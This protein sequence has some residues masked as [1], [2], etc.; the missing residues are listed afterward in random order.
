MTSHITVLTHS[1]GRLA[2]LWKAD[3]T[4]AAYD[5]TKY[6]KHRTV[7][8]TSIRDLA[9]ELRE[10]EGDPNSAV[11]RGLYR[12]DEIAAQADAEFKRGR[13]RKIKAVFD[14]VPLSW[15][16]VEID[17][18]E[19]KMAD[20]VRDPVA[21]IDEFVTTQ[22]PQAFH[23][24]SYHWQ[25]SG[26]AGHVKNVGKL[27]A[28]VW[29]WLTA[30][31]ISAQVK[32]WAEG[33]ALPIDCSV[34]N[35]VQFHYTAAPV[36]EEGVTVP[37]PARSGFVEGL[38]GDEVELSIAV[39]PRDG[40]IAS[41]DS[42][43]MTIEPRLGWTLEYGR[44]VLMDC[45]Q[46]S[47]R[48]NWRSALSAM[49]HEF[50]GSEEAL[51]ICDLWSSQSAKYEGRGDVEK[52]WYSFGKYTG[53]PLTGKWLLKWRGECIARRRYNAKAEW[54]AKIAGTLDEFTLREKVCADIAKDTCVG[55]LEREALA[56]ALCDQLKT[57]GAHYPIAQCRKMVA[58][59]RKVRPADEEAVVPECGHG[60]V[61]VTDRDKFFRVD[62]DEWLTTQAFNARFNHTMPTDEHGNITTTASWACLNS[63]DLTVTRAMY[64]PWAEDRFEFEGVQ[65]VNL[66]RPS[67]V[68][69]ASGSI[70]TKGRTA[71]D[72]VLRHLRL[73]T[74]DRQVLVDTMVAWIA[75]NVQYPG[76][77]IRWAI[78]IKGIEGDGKSLLGS[79]MASVMGRTNVRDISPKVLGTDFN[80]Y[81]EGACVG[82]LEELKMTGHNRYDTLN[83]L[84]PL[85]TNDSIP[86]HR[87]GQ[88]EYNI[89]NTTNYLAFT[90]HSDALPLGDTDRRFMIVFTPF[91]SSD[92]LCAA[93]G[94]PVGGAGVYFDSLHAAIQSH[95]AELRQ[96]LLDYP[97]P[98]NFRP[99]SSAPMT[100]EKAVM[101]ALSRS[102]E[103]EA[104]REIIEKGALGVTT[105]VFSSKCLT[106]ALLHHEDGVSIATTAVNRVA[107]RLGYTRMPKK[108]WWNGSTHILWVRGRIPS[109]LDELK[110]LLDASLQF[111]ASLLD[112]F[113][114][115]G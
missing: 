86:I 59:K 80:G 91:A 31:Y 33:A 35:T 40:G 16:L 113:E 2:K 18:F 42:W 57:I 17:E 43:L 44:S 48:D 87:K 109:G 4:V 64:L 98:E 106:D 110:V 24:I 68:P 76:V 28:H 1:T 84:K 10:L 77:K 30:P 107:S 102:P 82:V 46:D 111:S 69:K 73:L 5:E 22:L 78:L 58:E 71:I 50:A 70:S 62:S 74:G 108:V 88:D 55:E 34:L 6:Y 41:D 12:G 11:I 45:D 72:L 8:V 92:D 54:T 53:Q 97:I 36:A 104:A 99:N 47:G 14:D 81:A 29:F 39:T 19:P 21:A 95:P 100:D 96:W 85:I 3:G 101:V 67:S 65:C 63:S 90:N 112:F 49:H 52:R 103:E 60:W 105:T 51:D 66:Y 20:P 115:E 25:L 13:V 23:G 114:R 61:Y 79:I 32:A 56:K 93:L 37:V 15:F 26:S 27:K 75:H 9:F 89:V 83:S 94:L 38:F 7:E